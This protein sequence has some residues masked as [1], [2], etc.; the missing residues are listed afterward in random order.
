MKLYR[1][2]PFLL[3]IFVACISC[4][5]KDLSINEDPADAP[6]STLSFEIKAPALH[7]A[8]QQTNGNIMDKIRILAFRHNGSNYFYL[9]D[10]AKDN[11]QYEAGSNKIKG[12]A[13]LPAGDY[14]FVTLYGLPEASDQNIELSPCGSIDDALTVTHLPN[15][16]LEPIF[17]GNTQE[18][19]EYTLDP[20]DEEPATVT[21]SLSR[22]VARVDIIFLKVDTT[23]GKYTEKTGDD[24]FG[25]AGLDTFNIAFNGVNA[26][27]NLTDG[28][29]A[30]P[31]QLFNPAFVTD[32]SQYLI[33]GNA[34]QTTVGQANA[35]GTPFDYDAI[36]GEHIISGS[37]YISG[38]YLLPHK[39]ATTT[40]SAVLKL[41]SR[42]WQGYV[43]TRTIPIPQVP[44][45]RNK[46]SLIKIYVTGP[47]V[48]HT[49]T[50]FEITIN[51]AW[52]NTIEIP[53]EVL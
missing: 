46:V 48:Y 9:K 44:V 2:F 26:C 11:I 1:N 27:M 8:S 5:H 6:R 31:S 21:A 32:L 38:A 34:G 15:G 4:E 51:D 22:A 36:T 41:T 49:T 25:P 52:D 42:P 39:D 14:K 16:I 17:L 3:L 28:S 45:V 20:L 7:R 47:D 13:M 23:G 24:I 37:A 10:V 18:L 53:G 35:D 19:P 12:T 33:M 29:P 30:T 43:Y 50:N 40:S